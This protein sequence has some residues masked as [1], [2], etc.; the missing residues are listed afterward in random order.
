M[1]RVILREL[2][3]ISLL[4]WAPCIFADDAGCAPEVVWHAENIAA[5]L[6]NWDDVYVAYEKYRS[7]D[8]GSVAEGFS[9]SIGG[10]LASN[11]D[12]II[13][14]AELTKSDGSFKAFVLK[15]IDETLPNEMLHR[16]KE[17]A[18]NRCP[19]RHIDLCRQ[20]ANSANH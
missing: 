4:A 15:H 12:S 19:I 8:D 13:R 5:S 1:N 10:I 2:M 7:C 18:D 20:I 9:D 6:K 16:I 17:N 14:L 11:W 3:T